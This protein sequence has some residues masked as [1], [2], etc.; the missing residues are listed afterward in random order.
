MMETELNW[1]LNALEEAGK[2]AVK[3]D[4]EYWRA[5]Y[6]AEDKAVVELLGQYMREEGM[7]IFFDAVGNL[8][9][10][11]EGKSRDVI[12]VGSHRDTVRHGGK[13]D[14]MLGILAGIRAAG[15]LYREFGRPEKTLEVVAMAEEESSRFPASDYP[16]SSNIAGIMPRSALELTDADGVTLG[17]AIKEAGYRGEPLDRKR[18]EIK[19]F[20]EMHIEQGGVLEHEG[21]Q[22]GIIRSIVGQWGG[23]IDFVGEQN[24]A[25]T[26]PMDLRRDPVP[27]MADFIRDMFCRIK[28]YEGD[29]VLTMGKIDV[30]PGNANVIPQKVSVTYDLRSADYDLGRKVFAG[31]LNLQDKH[32]GAVKIEVTPA[33]EDRPTDL[34]PQ[35]IE[36]L[37]AVARELNYPY[38]IMNSGAG[39][40]SQNMAKSYP[41]N[42][43]FVPSVGGVSHHEKEYTKPEDLEAGLAVL[44]AY[45]K[46]L[47]W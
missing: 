16:G 31:I 38:K 28:P 32:Y 11:L 18:P 12:M 6:T 15:S 17:A 42:M 37:E 7:E 35:G 29:L 39:H 44:K 27:V 5:S 41:T 9:G 40:D 26:T 14:G 23:R 8:H 13:Y 20:I 36:E 34:D 1:L 25:G 24:H 3:K 43:I 30:W 47:S 33:W 22:I 46:K 45:L 10:V 21:K 19:R 4:G 2:T